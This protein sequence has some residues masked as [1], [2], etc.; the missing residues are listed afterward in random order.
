MPT[1]NKEKTP[2]SYVRGRL[3]QIFVSS[4]E[5]AA[6][7]KRDKYTCRDCG[8]KQSRAKGREQKIEIHHVNGTG[9]EEIIDLIYKKLL[10]D[11]NFLEC[12]CP[13]C[14]DKGEANAKRNFIR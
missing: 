1:K 2:R 10:C 13:E 9:M 14:H 8:K 4:R 12:K 5:R 11:P 6:A 7:L 3:R